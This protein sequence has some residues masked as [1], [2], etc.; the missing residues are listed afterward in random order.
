MAGT[1]SEAIALTGATGFIGRR[2]L[3]ALTSGAGCRIATL[4]RQPAPPGAGVRTVVGDLD[5]MSALHRLCE[6]SQTVFHCA[7]YA[8][9]LDAGGDDFAAVHWRVNAEG[10]RHLVEA[11]GRAGVKRLVHLS[12]VKAMAEPGEVRVD[13]D[14][15]GEPLSPYGKAKRAAEA[16]VLEAGSRYGM[17]VVNLRL[18][19]VYGPGSTRGNLDRMAR[20]IRRGWF[21]PLPETGNRRSLVH[22]DDVVAA[23]R[24]AADHPAANGRTY[25]L[26]EPV[27][28]SGRR[29]YELIRQALGLPRRRWAVPAALLRAAGWAGD[30]VGV[31]ARRPSPLNSE[32]VARLLESAWYSPQRIERELG[33]RTAIALPEGLAA[34]YGAS[35]PRDGA[36]G[37]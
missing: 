24:L 27:G 35:A 18:A 25:I 28:Y 31:L 33:W 16:A 5:D 19:M 8:H 21:P 37:D 20:L 2:L 11:A 1:G 6:G 14:W 3:A 4:V 29:I 9:A 32:V 13:E 7:G 22:V 10:T 30:G 15:P 23:A 17:H 34:I 12:S 36:D 26:A